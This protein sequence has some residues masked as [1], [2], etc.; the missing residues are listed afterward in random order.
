VNFTSGQSVVYNVILNGGTGPF[1]INLI[2]TATNAVANTI[3]WP[4]LTPVLNVITFGSSMPAT[5]SD[6]FNVIGT[7]TGTITT[8]FV[9]NSVSNTVTVNG[10]PTQTTTISNGGGGG[11]S[12]QTLTLKDNLTASIASNVSVFDVYITNSSGTTERTYNQDNLPATITY[13]LPATLNFAFAC[14]FSSGTTTYRYAGDI[15]GIG[16]DTPCGTN[17]TTYG[18][19][20][21]TVLYVNA[22][23]ATSTNSTSTSTTTTSTIGPTTTIPSSANVLATETKTVTVESNMTALARFYNNRTTIQIYSSIPETLNVTL[24]NLTKS[25]SSPQNYTKLYVFNLNVSTSANLSL[26]VTEY[27]NCSIPTQSLR[28]FYLSNSTWVPINKGFA[29]A[30]TCSITFA[31]PNMHTIGLFEVSKAL[32]STPSNIT[33]PIT[34][35]VTTTIPQTQKN[36]NVA[37]IGIVIVVIIVLAVAGA[38]YLSRRKRR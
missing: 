23:R 28:A 22:T 7:D 11:P 27:Y 16:F 9:F 14:A 24:K 1:T 35:S 33:Q 8:P 18:G 34:S 29:I 31:A 13:A 12:R 30:Q 4:T 36:N 32:S 20:T 10:V 19:T 5:G 15:Y 17:Y 2:N 26:N 3:L 37:V 38:Y 25:S 21:Y 6:T